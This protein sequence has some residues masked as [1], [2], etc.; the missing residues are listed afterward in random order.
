MTNKI[1]SLRQYDFAVNTRS[2]NAD[3]EGTAWGLFNSVQEAIVTRRNGTRNET[4]AALDRNDKL[5]DV[6]SRWIQQAA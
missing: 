6:F 4:G 1:I 2:R 3:A 5:A